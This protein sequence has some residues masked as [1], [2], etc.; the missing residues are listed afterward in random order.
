MRDIGIDVANVLRQ[1]G[2]PDDLLNRG[3]ITLST[4]DMFRLWHSIEEVVQDPLLPLSIGQAISFE[5]FDPAIFAAMCSPDLNTAFT[6]ISLYKR[7]CAP[8]ELRVSI[9]DDCTGIEVRWLDSSTNPPTAAI[10]TELV[11][12]VQIVRLGTRK[13]ISPLKVFSPVLPEQEDEYARYFG[14]HIRRAKHPALLFSADDARCRFLI[15]NND[16]WKFFEPDLQKQ[17]AELDSSATTSERVAATLLEML[18]GGDSSIDSVCRKL[19]L[20]KRTLQRRLSENSENY[21]SVLNTTRS[22]LAQHYLKDPE[23]SGSEISFLL[24]FEDPNSF[25]RAFRS[26]TGKTPEEVRKM[27]MV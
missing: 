14:V 13:M 4:P 22:K 24:G 8:I 15:V 2:L 6:R 10:L 17:L 23:L 20:S 25:F 7:L 9:K 11:Y 16:L 18:P 26:W 1:A 3:V 27:R 5:T 19:G 21:Q 12:F